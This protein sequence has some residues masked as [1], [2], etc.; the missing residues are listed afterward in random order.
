MHSHVWKWQKILTYKQKLTYLV[1]QVYL[2]HKK[3]LSRI[4]LNKKNPYMVKCL[5][6]NHSLML[7]GRKTR[8]Q[9]N[10][11]MIMNHCQTEVN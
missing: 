9:Q 3:D 1:L 8:M 6:A 4:P 5:D 2:I 10:L 11:K 7:R